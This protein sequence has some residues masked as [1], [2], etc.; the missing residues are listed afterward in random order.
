MI[1][2]LS[3]KWND[4]GTNTIKNA[5]CPILGQNILPP[6]GE[7]SFVPEKDPY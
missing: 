1:Y 7:I 5:E 4:F 2:D 6:L 3:W